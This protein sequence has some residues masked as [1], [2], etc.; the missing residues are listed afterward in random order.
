VENAR[1][2]ANRH[3]RA[4]SPPPLRTG[5][6]R[7]VHPHVDRLRRCFRTDVSAFSPQQG[8]YR[9]IPVP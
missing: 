2:P 8:P 9:D 4:V 6:L 7:S 5:H 3:G 1:F